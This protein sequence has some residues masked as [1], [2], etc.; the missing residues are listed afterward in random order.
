[1]TEANTRKVVAN[2]E[3]LNR[4]PLSGTPGAHPLGTGAGAASG[5]VAGAV[6]GLAVYGDLE[7]GLAETPPRMPT[8]AHAIVSAAVEIVRFDGG[9]SRSDELPSAAAE[10]PGAIDASCD[11]RWVVDSE[12]D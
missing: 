1:M 6:A 10:N 5:A 7:P 11:S 4:D 8:A 9:P 3:D 12:G 2:E